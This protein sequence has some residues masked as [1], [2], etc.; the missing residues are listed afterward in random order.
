ME[1]PVVADEDLAEPLGTEPERLR[2]EVRELGLGLLRRLEPDA[3]ALLL[4]AS[5]S[6][7]SPPFSKR[8]RNAASSGPSSPPP[9]AGSGRR[10]LGGSAAQLAVLRREEEALPR[11]RAPS[12]RRPSSSR[13]GGRTSSASRCEPDRPAGSASATRAGRARAPTPRPRAARAFTNG[14]ACAVSVG[15]GRNRTR[16]GERPRGSAS[17]GG[18]STARASRSLGTGEKR[19]GRNAKRTPIAPTKRAAQSE[20]RAQY[21]AEE[22]SE[23]DRPPHDEPD[24]RFI[25]PSSRSGSQRLHEADPRDVVHDPGEAGD[26]AEGD[27][28]RQ[29]VRLRRQWQRSARANST[30]VHRIVRPTPSRFEMRLVVKAASSGPIAQRKSDAD[31]QPVERSSSRTA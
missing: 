26:D 9:D 16:S 12:S 27:E 7:S 15:G 1:P 20:P 2:A 18:S 30:A 25:R 21:A 22:R 5:V 19:I 8:R 4:P 17:T 3:G 24:H 29:W 10:S 23:R 6:M 13:S 11:R 31:E 28:E 14:T